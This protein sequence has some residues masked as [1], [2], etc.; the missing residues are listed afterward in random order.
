MK[1]F[2]YWIGCLSLVE[3]CV[4]KFETKRQRLVLLSTLNGLVTRLSRIS[5]SA[6][7][8]LLFVMVCAGLALAKIKLVLG[9]V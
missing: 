1:A 4:D 2:V 9:A 6:C 3:E 7:L 5:T 8:L